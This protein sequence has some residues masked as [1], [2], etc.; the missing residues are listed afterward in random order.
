MNLD[1][2][3][4]Y[5]AFRSSRGRSRLSTA[6]PTPSAMAHRAA[7]DTAQRKPRRAGRTDSSAGCCI[8]L[9]L[10]PVH[11]QG[12]VELDLL[13]QRPEMIY[14]RRTGMV[15]SEAE[16]GVAPLLWVVGFELRDHPLEQADV[17]CGGL[18]DATLCTVDRESEV[19]QHDT[20][21]RRSRRPERLQGAGV[22]RVEV[23]DRSLHG[24][25]G[26]G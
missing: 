22:I 3:G 16:R 8:L 6:A 21:W 10:S 25:H 12:E 19:G 26:P 23:G 24:L 5:R 2:A 17:L 15:S 7:I 4:A 11:A 13:P 14:E 20:R 9:P 1:G 18:D